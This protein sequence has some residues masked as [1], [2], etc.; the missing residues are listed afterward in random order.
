M[1]I[2]NYQEGVEYRG[3]D[4]SELSNETFIRASQIYS[5]HQY[6]YFSWLPNTVAKNTFYNGI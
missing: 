2:C 1:I 4:K 5:R 3:Y 6:S